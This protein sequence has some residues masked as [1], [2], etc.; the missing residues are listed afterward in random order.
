VKYVPKDD[1]TLIANLLVPLNRG[2]VRS[3]SSLTFGA[4]YTF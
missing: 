4:E 2:G 3:R 1:V